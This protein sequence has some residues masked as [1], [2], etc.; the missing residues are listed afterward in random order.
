MS[1]KNVVE[2]VC[3]A[4]GTDLSQ[5]SLGFGLAVVRRDSSS[6]FIITADL[7]WHKAM[8]VS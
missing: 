2:P 5:D 4:L 3:E 7:M 6:G 1:Q 8:S